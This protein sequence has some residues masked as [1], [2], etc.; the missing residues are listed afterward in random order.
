MSALTVEEKRAA[1]EAHLSRALPKMPANQVEDLYSNQFHGPDNP[2]YY[3]TVVDGQT[4]A[5]WKVPAG[6]SPEPLAE[7]EAPAA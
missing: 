3:E 6:T 7:E 5:K 2:M 1:L 4:V